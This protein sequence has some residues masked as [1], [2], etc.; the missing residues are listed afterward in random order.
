M[1]QTTLSPSA[2]DRIRSS[3][4]AQSLMETFG[5]ELGVIERGHVEITAPILPGT[6]QQHGYAHA[7]LTFSLGDS[8][9][10]YAALSVMPEGAEVM[11][12]EIKINLLAPAEGERLI[13]V[14]KVV[15]PG[16][17][18]VV[19]SAEVFAENA[20]TRKQVALLQGTMIPV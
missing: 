20:G 9:A 5:A 1:E 4:G 2:I 12:V 18:L 11:S 16:R 3:F 17:R 7:G 13:A 15:K 8:A 19:V 6:L 14:G 10:G